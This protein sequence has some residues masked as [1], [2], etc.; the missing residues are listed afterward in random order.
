MSSKIMDGFVL[1]AREYYRRR[2]VSGEISFHTWTNALS[3]IESFGHFLNRPETGIPFPP[4]HAR[5]AAYFRGDGAEFGPVGR[6]PDQP[7]AGALVRDGDGEGKN[8]HFPNSDCQIRSSLHGNATFSPTN[9]SI[10]EKFLIF[11]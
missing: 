1:F 9:T 11:V 6:A 2:Y 3:Q 4:G 10:K 8:C 7:P 5:R